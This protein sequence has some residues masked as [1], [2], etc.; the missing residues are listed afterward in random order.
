MRL[1]LAICVCLAAAPTGAAELSRESGADP[2]F[3]TLPYTK[4]VIK[5][6][7]QVGRVLEIEFDKSETSIDFAIGDRE[8]WAVKIDKNVVYL[9]PKSA[10][11]DTNLKII[12]NKRQY[13]FDLSMATKK[14]P[15]WWHI[16]FRYPQE[17][18]L[19]VPIALPDPAVIAAKNA[20]RQRKTIE[21][22]LGA[23][24]N[25]Q[26]V[27]VERELNGNYEVI[28]PKEITPTSA[29]DN[30]EFT[31]MTFMAGKPMPKVFVL[32]DDGSDARV[33][34]HVDGNMLVV[35]RVAKR[36]VLERGKQR[37][38]MTNKNYQPTGTN[39][40]TNTISNYVRRELK[41]AA[42]E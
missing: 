39:I 27:A 30:G 14:T 23:D 15:A 36:L 24:L 11:P 9:K 32:E 20:A 31:A 37:A 2:R 26:V 6:P 28:G 13:W 8:A 16:G 41:G 42:D 1:L 17:A 7:T 18:P 33:P 3:Q 12:T 40:T 25:L 21:E 29:Y 22:R 10:I 19:P 5:V 38:I 4:D 35:H 34:F